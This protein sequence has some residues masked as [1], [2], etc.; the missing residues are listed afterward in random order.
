VDDT[1]GIGRGPD[2]LGRLLREQTF[3]LRALDAAGFRAW[4]DSLMARWDRDPVFRQR[5]AVCELRRAHPGLRR[6]EDEYRRS[7][8]ADRASPVADRLRDLEREV[9]RARKAVAGLTA[10]LARSPTGERRRLADK[11]DGWR[12]TL[13][14]AEAR[15]AE[16]AGASPER[17]ALDAA[18]EALA[19]G[20]TAAGLDRAEA[21]LAELLAERGRRADRAGASFEDVTADLTGRVIAPE[22]SAGADVRVLRQVRLGTAGA[23]FD[24]LVVRA[25]GDL[26]VEVLAAVEA[27]ADV[28][29]LAHGFC[30]RQADLTWLTG[31]P[32]GYDPAAHRTRAFPSGHFDRPAV[33]AEGGEEFRF[34]PGS[35]GLFRRDAAAGVFLD[36]VYLVSRPGPVWG[37]SPTALARVAARV[38]ADEDWDPDDPGYMARLGGW[39]RSLA[40]PVET[41]DVL[42]LYAGSPAN[43]RQVLLAGPPRA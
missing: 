11:L 1:G 36:R 27:K 31:E 13:R 6:L 32:G 38:A 21:R 15:Y 19:T 30:R 5:A 28:N 20:R 12:T 18:R 9:G 40:G 16:L 22:V 35:F 3:D 26:P 43:A 33:H 10:A 29:G 17:R 34:G 41:P 23:E 14:D 39:C 7:A 25:R 37:L 42:R 2:V 4:L 24:A 8:A